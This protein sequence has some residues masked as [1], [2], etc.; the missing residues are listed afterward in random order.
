MGLVKGPTNGHFAWLKS[1]WQTGNGSV[2]FF[3]AVSEIP[4]FF[5]GPPE[6]AD[7][8]NFRIAIL[9]IFRD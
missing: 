9:T 3:V 4:D 1:I 7:M 5:D 6:G 2:F 8:F